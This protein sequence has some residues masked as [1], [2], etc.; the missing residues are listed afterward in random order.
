MRRPAPMAASGTKVAGTSRP[1]TINASGHATS[2]PDP[3]RTDLAA[4]ERA[5]TVASPLNR[6]PDLVEGRR[7]ATG[8]GPHGRP[9]RYSNSLPARTTSQPPTRVAR[10]A[11]PAELLLIRN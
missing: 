10:S 8:L 6:L 1:T 4:G 11:D 3:G 2:S 9:E 5:T 7:M